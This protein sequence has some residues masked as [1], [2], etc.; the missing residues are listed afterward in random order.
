M[1]RPFLD[2]YDAVTL[3]EAIDLAEE[4]LRH[5][6]AQ[7]RMDEDRR[8]IEGMQAEGKSLEEIVEAF[9]AKCG[10]TPAEILRLAEEALADPEHE[11][12]GI[13]TSERAV[14]YRKRLKSAC[15]EAN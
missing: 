12:W 10:A 1:G 6:H 11:A 14:T 8:W 9:A 4:E 3:A 13:G 7:Q 15:S 2:P 5:E